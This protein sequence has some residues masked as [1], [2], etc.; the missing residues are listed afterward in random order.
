MNFGID[1]RN[2]ES[3]ERAK[4]EISTLLRIVDFAI[5]EHAVPIEPWCANEIMTAVQQMPNQFTTSDVVI[6]FGQT[7][8]EKRSAIKVALADAV[9]TGKLRVVRHGCGR[10]PNVYEKPSPPPFK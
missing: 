3:L 4:S 8:K 6:A 1:V 10:R 7:G 5:A 9:A 2:R